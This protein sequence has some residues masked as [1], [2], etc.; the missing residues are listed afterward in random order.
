MRIWRSVSPTYLLRSSGPL[1][2]RKYER[3]SSRPSFAATFLASEFA[4]A[5]ATSVLPHPGGP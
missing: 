1:M 2:L 5:L 4:T 3:R